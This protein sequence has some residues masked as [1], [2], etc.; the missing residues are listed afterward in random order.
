MPEPSARFPKSARILKHSSFQTV[1]QTGRR[2][3]SP[4]FTAFFVLSPSAV[5]GARI[6]ITVGRVLGNAVTRNRIKRRT[7][8]AVRKHLA[9]LNAAVA[10]RGV[11][12]EVVFNPKKVCAEVEFKRLLGEVERAFG[13]VAKA[14]IKESKRETAE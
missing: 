2:H 4:L 13:V 14:K 12:A 5:P 11:E 8:E 10:D 6:G 7:R 3:F 1:Y 9:A